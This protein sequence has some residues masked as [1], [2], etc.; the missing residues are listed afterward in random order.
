MAVFNGVYD[1][2]LGPVTQFQSDQNSTEVLDYGKIER[3]LGST[4]S[5]CGPFPTAQDDGAPLEC[6]C[7]LGSQQT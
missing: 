1:L 3:Q 6:S 7:I 4:Y 2:R 5:S